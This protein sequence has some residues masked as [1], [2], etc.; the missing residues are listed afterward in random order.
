MTDGS[1]Q[2]NS[3]GTGGGIYAS[4]GAKV[5]LN[6]VVFSENKA[7]SQGGAIGVYNS[8]TVVNA[9]ATH[10]LRNE[11]DVL[12]G[13]VAI[14]SGKFTLKRSNKGCFDSDKCN[15]FD[16]NTALRFGGAIHGANLSDID[17][18][19]TYFENNRANAGTAY[20]AEGSSSSHKI[21]GSVFIQNGNHAAGGYDDRDV[22]RA[23]D[24][25]VIT[26]SYSTFAD[27]NALFSTLSLGWDS[28]MYVR[29]S[30]IYDSSSGD[31]FDT[32]D[33]SSHT[34]D[35]LLVHESSSFDANN[36]KVT[37]ADPMFI[38]AA[39]QNYHIDAALSP[40]V[41]YCSDSV[42]MAE[43][44]DI[45]FQVRGF[46]NELIVNK[47]GAYDIGADESLG[48]EIFGDGFE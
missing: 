48:N 16:G 36:A 29:S 38:D 17:I 6:R 2:N 42:A 23:Y 31:V 8:S 32:S 35:C 27:N 3:S 5:D 15:L 26:I 4:S 39:N 40:A 37:V 28:H 45:D 44:E 24:H 7:T 14:L 20:N 41:D 47:F 1:F 10:F 18:S 9:E 46:D 22:I 19:S 30:I 21:E 34:V 43:H 33:D 13:A 11:S 25:A 12:G